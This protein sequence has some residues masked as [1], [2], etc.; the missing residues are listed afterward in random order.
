MDI[1]EEIFDLYVNQLIPIDSI[2]LKL[3]PR[4]TIREVYNI[5]NNF[6]EQ[7][8]KFRKENP[9]NKRV[10]P[11]VNFCCIY[12]HKE[13]NIN[14]D[15]GLLAHL[16][17]CKVYRELNNRGIRPDDFG[18]NRAWNRGLKIG[19]NESLDKFYYSGRKSLINKYGTVAGPLI[20]WNKTKNDFKH[21][22]YD[23]KEISFRS[24][25]ELQLAKI[26]ESEKINYKYEELRFEYFHTDQN[27]LRKYIPDFYLQ[28]YN[29]II[30]FKLKQNLNNWTNEKRDS[31][32]NSG[33]NFTY[34]TEKECNKD[35]LLDI[36]YNKNYKDS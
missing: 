3:R 14:P 6:K 10:L 8:K 34:V 26:L 7:R 1:V 2:H 16:G 21:I 12:C 25:W 32:K 29:L 9:R 4:I 35:S 33:Y 28:D 15:Q 5:C 19:D 20:E 18:D 36:I 23:G 22:K 13:M 17:H 31:V 30:E 11:H 24:G 27:K